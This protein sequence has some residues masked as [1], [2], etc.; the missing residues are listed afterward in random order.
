MSLLAKVLPESWWQRHL[1]VGYKG[2]YKGT[3]ADA[4]GH[5]VTG[6]EIQHV[7]LEYDYEEGRYE[8]VYEEDE[9]YWN[10]P[11]GA[12]NEYRTAGH[13][14]AVW[15]SSKTYELGSH[16]QADVAE[17]LDVGAER[18]L[19]RDATVHVTEIDVEDPT[20]LS[21]LDG[22]D[23]QALADGGTASQWT[24]SVTIESPGRLEDQLINL[25]AFGDPGAQARVVS[26]EKYYE[27]YPEAPGSEE[28]RDQ[29]EAGRLAEMDQ[30]ADQLAKKMLIIA[31]LIIVGALAMP[32]LINAVLG[33]GGGGGGGI[34]PG[35]IAIGSG[36]V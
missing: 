26:M 35:M 29:F 30:N 13:V 27:T 20:D 18:D 31:G 4:V 8:P 2:L 24:E 34:L 36:G 17:A 33:G 10:A 1:K 6:N 11:S 5:I 14:P 15:A 23:P 9:A 25:D 19:Y 12:A 21:S 22:G 7:P 16:V 3:D 28:Q 32:A